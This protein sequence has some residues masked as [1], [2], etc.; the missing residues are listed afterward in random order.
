MKTK[1]K[2]LVKEATIPTIPS[3]LDHMHK[4]VSNLIDIVTSLQN[5]V[6]RI[7]IRMGI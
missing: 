3:E 1:T 6:K 7:K 2:K 5:D 4:T